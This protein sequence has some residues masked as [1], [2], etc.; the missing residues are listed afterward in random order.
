MMRTLFYMHHLGNGGA[1]RFLL[2]LL[3]RLDKRKHQISLAIHADG[4]RD[5]LPASMKLC[6]YT[7]CPAA[8]SQKCGRSSN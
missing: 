1:A 6:G 4:L 8:K 5:Y 3:N 2:N 7:S